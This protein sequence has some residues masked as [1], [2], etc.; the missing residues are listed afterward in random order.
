MQIPVRLVPAVLTP[1]A[2]EDALLRR[3]RGH[4]R[5]GRAADQRE[6]AR[7]VQP[8]A[9]AGA[10]GEELVLERGVD[11]PDDRVLVDEEADGDAEHGED[12]SVVYRSWS[13]VSTLPVGCCAVLGYMYRLMGRYTMLDACQ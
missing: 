11:Y 4:R 10:R 7:F 8:G 1:L 2:R 12:M 5:D 3:S 13:L 9:A 6:L